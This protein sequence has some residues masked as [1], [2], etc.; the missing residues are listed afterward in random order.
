M[1]ESVVHS[2]RGCTHHGEPTSGRIVRTRRQVYVLTLNASLRRLFVLCTGSSIHSLRHGSSKN[3]DCTLEEMK[4][5]VDHLQRI[6]SVGDRRILF[7]QS[8]STMCRSSKCLCRLNTLTK[9]D[10]CHHADGGKDTKIQAAATPAGVPSRIPPRWR[11]H[12]QQD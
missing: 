12:V 3:I 6:I 10:D 5:Y 4:Q 8:L 7:H 2:S 11:S 9:L 1:G